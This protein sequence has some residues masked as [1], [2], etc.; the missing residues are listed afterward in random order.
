MEIIQ[1]EDTDLQAIEGKRCRTFQAKSQSLNALEIIADIHT[2]HRKRVIVICNTVSQ[3]QGLYRDLQE[4]NHD[5][6]LNITLLHSRFLPEHRAQKEAFLKE[7]F[8]E[9]WQDDGTC[10]VLI[11]TQVIEAGINITCEVMH[12]QLCPMNSLLQRAGRCARF[13]DEQ[14]EVFVYR[15]VQVNQAY[16]NLA[17]ADIDTE[18]EAATDKKPS[19]LPYAQETCELTWQVLQAHTESN[20]VHENVG[21]RTEETWINQVHTAEDLLQQQRR[22]N[23]QMQFENNFEAAFFRGENYT[24]TELIRYVDSRSLFVW[25]EGG[26]FIDFTQ[27]P[28][29]PRKLISF[30]VP[31][32][33]LCKVWREFKNLEFGAD[34]IFKRIEAPKDKAETYSQPV[35]TEIKS[36]ESLINSIKILVNPRYIYY[37]ENIGLLIG[38]NEFG[39]G[40]ISPPKSQRSIVSEYRYQMDTYVG[41]LG[42]MWTCWRKPFKTLSLKNGKVEPTIYNSV[43]NELLPTGT[44][45]IKNKIFPQIQESEAAVLFEL[46][47]FFAIFTHD[48]GKLQIKWQEVM[49]KWQAIAHSSF[50]GQNPKQHLLAHTDYNPE[51]SQQKIALKD[52]EKK[53]KRP[54]HAV[55]S[56]FLARDILTQSLVPLLRDYFEA[57]NEQIQNIWWVVLMATGRHHSAWSNGWEQSDTVKIKNIQLH[58][59]AQR[60]IAQ[61]WQSMTR[62]L[63]P[64]LPLKSANLSKTM[65]PVKSKFDLSQLNSADTFEYFHLYLLVVRALRLCDQ[66]SVQLNFHV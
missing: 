38:V 49:R 47:V 18:T 56:A 5:Y 22:Q 7:I 32:S 61:S 54:N 4:I 15:T 34:W 12:S 9:N 29:D 45:L 65:Y 36:R 1:I 42:C 53:H 27:E 58:P 44:K 24:A 51:D 16:A 41:H 63:P 11:S 23:N 35:C 37:D 66:R 26:L 8:A 55:E 19:F 39:N 60:A 64:T 21:F 17:E 25:E 33:T 59:E 46:L 40:F 50:Q 20:Q 30:S 3:A 48:L 2:R 43:K 6:T 62:F 31:V 28:I 14:G 52:H 10:Y 13:Q 57:D